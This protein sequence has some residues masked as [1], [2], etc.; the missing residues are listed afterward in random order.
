LNGL[1]PH[2]PYRAPEPWLDR[3]T[4]PAYDGG[5]S[6]EEGDIVRLRRALRAG[7]ATPADLDQ[8]AAR[9]LGEVAYADHH[10]GLLLSALGERGLLDH[11]LIVATADHG[12]ALGENPASA[13]AHGRTV[14][15]GVMRVPLIAKGIGLP[16]ARG[17]VIGTAADLSGLAPTLEALLGLPPTLGDGVGFPELL[18][19]GPLRDE[20]G[21]PERP[22]RVTFLEATRATRRDGPGWN[23]LDLDRGVRVGGLALIHPRRAADRLMGIAGAEAAPE[24]HP[25]VRLLNS[26]LQTWDRAA[27]P[28]RVDTM[29]ADTLDALRA[30]GYIG[31]PEGS[32]GDGD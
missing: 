2:G 7:T 10:V 24:D 4:D 29:D 27:P 32:P 6:G 11:A 17:A 15:E 31:G 28:L 1:D 5:Y 18:R 19:D 22:T 9:Y 26:L 16:I 21:W 14:D 25:A 12:E 30:L 13:W 8:V 3:Y 20:D 23:N